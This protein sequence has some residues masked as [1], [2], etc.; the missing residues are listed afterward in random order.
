MQKTFC[1]L[2]PKAVMSRGAKSAEAQ[3]HWV[4]LMAEGANLIE[5]RHNI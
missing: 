4:V 2:M 1:S 5:A 3:E